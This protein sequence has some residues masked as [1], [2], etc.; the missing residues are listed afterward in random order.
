MFELWYAAAFYFAY[1]QLRERSLLLPV[2]QALL[3]LFAFGYLTLAVIYGWA[4]NP[5]LVFGA[6]LGAMV[7]SLYW[8]RLPTGLP[9]FLRSY[10][11]GTLDVLA[12]RRPTHD[13]KRRVR[14]K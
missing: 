7:V 4:A 14:T 11:R 2:L 13:L 6:L 3:M 1:T 9:L 5:L 8:R 10:P 12:F